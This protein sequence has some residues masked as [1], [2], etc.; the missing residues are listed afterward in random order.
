MPIELH[1]EVFHRTAEACQMA[2]ISRATLFRWLSIG[3]VGDV[4]NRDR[5]GW[6]LFSEFDINRLKAEAN[7][8]TNEQG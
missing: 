2:G 8:I 4:Q 1:G 6:R 5:R 3:I 7:R